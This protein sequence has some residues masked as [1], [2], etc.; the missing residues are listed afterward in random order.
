MET[1]SKHTLLFSVIAAV[2]GLFLSFLWIFNG[3]KSSTDLP[4]TVPIMETKDGKTKRLGALKF[5]SGIKKE[6]ASASEKIKSAEISRTESLHT[7][8]LLFHYNPYLLIWGLT[9]VILTGLASGAI[10]LVRDRI[11]NIH[12]VFKIHWSVLA[13]MVGGVAFVGFI[14]YKTMALPSYLSYY[15]FWTP[16][17]DVI[18]EDHSTMKWVARGILALALPSLLGI[19]LL[20]RAGQ[21]L[22]NS[23][24]DNLPEAKKTFLKKYQELRSALSFFLIILTMLITLT[25][26]ATGAFRKALLTAVV[27]EGLDIAPVEFVYLYGLFFTV[28]LA[29][30]YTPVYLQLLDLKQRTK[31]VKDLREFQESDTFKVT[32]WE[33]IKILASLLAPLLSSIL[34]G[35]L[36]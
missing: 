2:L 9:I 1:S 33:T 25:V 31:S 35:F 28:F 18:F 6:I 24:T 15:T 23:L 4:K 10:P 17:A 3:F 13:I 16:F 14:M 29:L 34:P 21:K 20:F 5:E 11:L 12:K 26:I 27:V 32:N 36:S 19:A 30:F 8:N 22:Q 7:E